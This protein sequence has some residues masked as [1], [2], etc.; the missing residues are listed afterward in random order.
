M[1][2]ERF[3]S[4]REI[5]LR[6]MRYFWEHGYHASSINDLVNATDVS[7]HSFYSEFDGKHELFLA[8]LKLYDDEVVTPAFSRVES[9]GA[10]LREIAQYFEFQI[11]LADQSGLPGPGCLVANTFTEVAP[12]HPEVYAAVE[13]HNRRLKKGFANA[14]R[15]AN[16]ENLLSNKEIGELASFLVVSAQGLWSMSRGVTNVRTLRRYVAT[17][18]KLIRLRFGS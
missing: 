1:P 6:A 10:G 14:L 7:R 8:C 9:S 4:T 3:Y 2:R 15:D 11:N 13:R 17:L 18:L 16:K 5:T 12:H